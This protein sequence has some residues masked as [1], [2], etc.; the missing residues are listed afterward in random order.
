[1]SVTASSL[2]AHRQTALSSIH[3]CNVST[4]L[5]DRRLGL[6]PVPNTS[7]RGFFATISKGWASANNDFSDAF[8]Y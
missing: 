8:L 5:H 2:F 4:V 7:K 6:C 3:A 1:M